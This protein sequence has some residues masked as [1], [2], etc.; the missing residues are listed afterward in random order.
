VSLFTSPQSGY[1]KRAFIISP[2]YFLASRAFE[3]AGFAEKLTAITS[4]KNSIDFHSLKMALNNI[5]LYVPDVP[6]NIA[7]QS[8]LRIGAKK[9]EKRLYKYVLYATPTF[10][11][12]TGETWDLETRQKL[13][14]IARAWDMLVITDDVYDFLG[15]QVM[16]Q[17]ALVPR[18]VSLDAATIK[19]GD[20][21]NTISNCSFSKLLGPGLRCGWIETASPVLASQLGNAGAPHSGGCPSQFTSM[22]VHSLL[23][24]S[25]G[26]STRKID[27]VI[28]NLTR[29]YTKRC[30]A[31]R[32]AID[33]YLPQ[34]TEIEGGKGGFFAWLRLPEG[35]DAAEVVK[36]AAE[37]GV[38]VAS[39]GMSE[40]PGKENNMG[41][42]TRCIRISISY[43]EKDQIVGGIRRLGVAVG[44]WKAGERSKEESVVFVK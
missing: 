9:E 21:G 15:N 30:D 25:P 14:E 24:Q 41:W 32:K 35:V 38:I 12:P 36:L 5:D 42:G 40:C 33:Y 8:S 1:T 6:L 3:D 34:G 11:N 16:P 2:T 37:E 26:N 44:R 29:T 10:S 31:L 13:L 19:P 27:V 22:V 17:S 20:T 43:C 28:E 7:L 23:V 4:T 18:L 39:G